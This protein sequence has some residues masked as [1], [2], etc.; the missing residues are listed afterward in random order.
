[1]IDVESVIA[2]VKKA[3]KIVLSHYNNFP[4]VSVEYKKDNS[5]LTTADLESNRFITEAL[6]SKF[7]L[8]V[9][10]EEVIIPY[11]KRKVFKRFWLID[12]LDGTKDFSAKTG[13]FTINI[14]L[15]DDCNPALGVIYAPYL[16]LFC[17]AKK[18]YGTYLNGKRIFNTSDR[19]DLIATDSIFHSSI[20]TQNFLKQNSLNNVLKFGSALKF[21]KLAEGIVD[22]YPRFEGSKEWDIAAGHI[23]LKE[24]GC[25]I[26][27]I[28]TKKEPTYNKYS[29]KNNF[30]IAAKNNILKNYVY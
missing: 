6:I 13:Q 8:P 10:S 9:V 19:T 21:C 5:P 3:G 1:M 11:E 4:E 15:I 20:K 27:D 18:G 28:T 17:Y 12:P 26:I 14:A 2:I 24:A 25:N 30:F 7:N 22:I 16:N 29:M 23:I